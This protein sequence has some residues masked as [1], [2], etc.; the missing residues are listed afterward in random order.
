MRGGAGPAARGDLLLAAQVLSYALEVV[1]LCRRWLPWVD[2]IESVRALVFWC[3]AQGMRRAACMS[4]CSM[5]RDSPVV[6][7]GASPG[8][9]GN[10]PMPATPTSCVSASYAMYSPPTPWGRVQ[11]FVMNR[12]RPVYSIYVQQE[13]CFGGFFFATNSTSIYRVS[14]ATILQAR[15]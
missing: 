14:F 1:S 5:V 8:W 3:A 11:S 2:D 13:A 9:M 15:L 6:E 7:L 4:A 12:A 10:R